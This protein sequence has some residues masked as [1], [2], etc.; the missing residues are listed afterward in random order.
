MPPLPE[1]IEQLSFIV[2][3]PAILI[4]TLTAGT[5]VVVKDWR[6]SLLAL[7]IQYVFVGLLLA[8]AIRLE[9]A[10]IKTLVGAMLCLILYMTARRVNWGGP[11]AVTPPDE[12]LKEREGHEMSTSS[13]SPQ[14]SQWILPTE[15]PFRFLAVLLVIV[16][17]YTGAA[18]YPLP[19]VGENISLAVYTLAALGMLAMGLTDEPLKSGLGLLTFLSAFELFYTVL[20]PSLAVV[21]F[22]GLVNFLIA[23]AIAYL[24]VVRSATVTNALPV[25]SSKQRL[26]EL[27]RQDQELQVELERDE[28]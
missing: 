26:G 2:S 28:L 18:A 20:E 25:A 8:G 11:I 12:T 5:M 22:L 3:V 10:A 13:Q 14:W 23:L 19:D 27:G 4:V 21:G 9:L 7:I 1:I 16:A 17:V 24:T 15:L 6:V